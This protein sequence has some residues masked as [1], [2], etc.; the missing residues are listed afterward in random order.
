MRCSVE[1]VDSK[2]GRLTGESERERERERAGGGGGVKVMTWCGHGVWYVG[3][4]G[5]EGGRTREF[6]RR[7]WGSR[8][9]RKADMTKG[10]EGR[11]SGER[12]EREGRE[13][14]EKEERV[15]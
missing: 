12:A 13:R 7:F 3:E 1:R 14:D 9:S 15:A 2:D 5:H 10:R 4:V 8:S 6:A 11:E